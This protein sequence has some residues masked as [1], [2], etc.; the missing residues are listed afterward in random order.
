M[1]S[2]RRKSE[3]AFTLVWPVARHKQVR[4]VIAADGTIKPYP[5]AN[6]FH[7]RQISFN[8][9]G[10]L[11]QIIVRLQKENAFVI[12]A[13]P[14]TD[15]QPVWKGRVGNNV[16]D[17]TNGF[18]SVL[19]AWLPLDADGIKLPAL[20]D[21][22][23]DPGAAVEYAVSKLPECFWDCSYVWSFTATH[24][25]EKSGIKWTGGIIGDEIR[26]RLWFLLSRGLTDEDA[27]GWITAMQASFPELDPSVCN[28]SQAIY[29][30]RAVL[31]A[32]GADPLAS[33]GVQMCGIRIGLE[34]EVHVPDD[35]HE[36]VRWAKAEGL[37]AACARHPSAEA[38]IKAIG[39]PS[40]KGGR[41]EV[42]SHLMAAALKTARNAR[43]RGGEASGADVHATVMAGIEEHR[44]A[45]TANLAAYGRR[46]DDVETYITPKGAVSNLEELCFWAAGRAAE[47]DAK[48]G[49]GAGRAKII[50]RIANPPPPE[51]GDVQIVSLEEARQ[52]AADTVSQF[53]AEVGRYHAA[54]KE[55]EALSA[56]GDDEDPDLSVEQ[57]GLGLT[58]PAAA[59]RPPVK[60]LAAGTGVGKTHVSLEG[61]VAIIS[62]TGKAVA[63]ATPSITLAEEVAR[64]AEETFARLD[65]NLTVAVRRGRERPDPL[66]PEHTMCRRLEDV[67]IVAEHGLGIGET[68]CEAR[69]RI[70]NPDGKKETVITRCP[71]FNV[72]GYQRQKA[73]I[74]A[75]DLVVLA[76]NHIFQGVPEDM[77]ELA[78]VMVDEA[79]WQ[80]AL[81]GC[82]APV[83]V[84][85]GI[86]RDPPSR[87]E[88]ELRWMRRDLAKALDN[89]PDGPVARE[90]LVA[91][92]HTADRAREL[93]WAGVE[94]LEGSVTE[95]TG[96]NLRDALT[97]ATGGAAGRKHASRMS[98]VWKAVEA[99][100]K[101]EDGQRSGLLSLDTTDAETGGRA[102]YVKW[103]AEVATGWRKLPMLLMDAT[104]DSEVMGLVFPGLEPAPRYVVPNPHV[105]IRQIVDRS[106]AHKVMVPREVSEE[107][108]DGQKTAGKRQNE[109]AASNGRKIKAKLITDAMSR[110]GGQK[111]LAI[112]PAAVE[113]QWRQGWLPDWL[114]LLHHGAV[115]GLDGYGDVR[116]V[117]SI[118]R[119]L[120]PPSSLEVEA[121]AL[122][123]VAV[124]EI[125]YRQ[126]KKLI[127]LVDGTAVEVET[128]VHPDPLCDRLR[129]QRTEA[130]KIQAAWGRGRPSSRTEDSP[131]DILVWADTP[132]PELGPV[133]AELWEGPTLDEQMLAEGAWVESASDAAKVWPDLVVNRRVLEKGRE[134][135]DAT[136]GYKKYLSIAKSGIQIFE[137]RLQGHRGASHKVVFLNGASPTEA[138]AFLESKLGPM[139]VF[140]P[141]DP[142]AATATTDEP[143]HDFD[144]IAADFEDL[145][146]DPDTGGIDASGVDETVEPE[147]EATS[148]EP[149]APA[150]A[151]LE[152]GLW[153]EPEGDDGSSAQRLLRDMP[154]LRLAAFRPQGAVARAAV[155]D[156][157]VCPE[158]WAVLA[159]RLGPLEVWAELHWPG[160]HQAAE[161]PVE[162][163]PIEDTVAEA[164]AP[165]TPIEAPATP[166]TDPA[167]RR[168]VLVDA[169]PLYVEAARLQRS[170]RTGHAERVS[171]KKALLPGLGG[172]KA[173]AAT[174]GL[175][176]KDLRR[177]GPF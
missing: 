147:V 141:V 37:G 83:S 174:P 20:T 131:L 95:L 112:V 115:T 55:Y 129:W 74:K 84:G 13:M 153:V 47:D 76:H 162:D 146:P 41:S 125:G 130:G 73:E 114:Q 90:H 57:I 132:L 138:K 22:R 82:G 165:V 44:A 18:E 50:T 164:P 67:R 128:S 167:P 111:V 33:L 123:G 133:E 103:K 97:R 118:G 150:P 92:A 93:E 77:P 81:H 36:T 101:L 79:A 86:L 151:T 161:E 40:A 61:A 31:E 54:V 85:T 65:A 158:P 160:R 17:P 166:T 1:S 72:C 91:L 169:G 12:R 137:Y 94:G 75:A 145:G 149:P 172:G 109:A 9:I 104:G 46:W 29:T 155:W 171:P 177:T 106:F 10:D 32:D 170:A 126:R 120:P 136:F 62:A 16:S 15:R 119:I 113:A 144:D 42:R 173:Q 163:A 11:H 28:V 63:F 116:A 154:H 139:A 80:G 121:G 6:T 53:V 98:A 105:R 87:V 159:A 3:R 176:G 38:A 140:Q 135:L 56:A 51:I 58:A 60:M 21:W 134:I 143:V 78:A 70:K 43:E 68:L 35:L 148:S 168:P 71:L 27:R 99:A 157:A 96:Q 124:E 14:A 122:T 152:D 25:L 117:Y 89:A 34:D 88:D 59:P 142:S 175:L 19:R 52:A 48:T 69:R 30:A 110:Y 102:V 156:P 5:K 39:L 127:H 24:G 100:A 45:I 108:K 2:T 23:E 64:R 4:K 66:A 8:T 26:L 49:D 107:F 7:H